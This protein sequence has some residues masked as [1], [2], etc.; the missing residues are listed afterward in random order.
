MI[1]VTIRGQTQ[2]V[3]PQDIRL[4]RTR[5]GFSVVRV[6]GGRHMIPNNMVTVAPASAT[7]AVPAVVPAVQAQVPLPMP[8]PNVPVASQPIPTVRAQP[9]SVPIPTVQAQPLQP[10]A[11]ININSAGVFN[12]ASAVAPTV[13]PQPAAQFNGY[14]NPVVNP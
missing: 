9:L 1:Q 10:A 11:N 13:R 12:P 14:M 3:L 7:P 5:P 8:I 2:Q 6:K 4:S